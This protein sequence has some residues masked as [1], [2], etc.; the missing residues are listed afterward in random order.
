MS[1]VGPRPPLPY[2]VDYLRRQSLLYDLRL[3]ALTLPAVLR[4]SGAA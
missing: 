2:D 1:L 3:I 4:K